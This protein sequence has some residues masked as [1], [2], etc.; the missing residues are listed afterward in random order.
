MYCTPAFASLKIG[1]HWFSWPTS[2][3]LHVLLNPENYCTE[4]CISHFHSI[5][6]CKNE[7]HTLTDSL[8]C[9]PQ[10]ELISVR[11]VTTI[12]FPIVW[13]SQPVHQFRTKHHPGRKL[14]V[15]T[16]SE[17][18]LR[19]NARPSSIHALVNMASY[20][21]MLGAHLALR[22]APIVDGC[23]TNWIKCRIFTL[24]GVVGQSWT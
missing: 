6:R 16:S 8:F 2:E 24:M 11:F 10:I 13:R 9:G 1:N 3:S 14:E 23:I 20:S 21:M 7:L 17:F 18:P 12:E 5:I 4:I 22:C 19:V 15:R